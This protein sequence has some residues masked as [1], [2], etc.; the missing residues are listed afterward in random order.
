MLAKERQKTIIDI[1]SEKGSIGIHEL[2]ERLDVSEATVRND[3]KYLEQNGMLKRLHGGAVDL[4][5]MNEI[6]YEQRAVVHASEKER[7]GKKAAGL[8]AP[9]ETIFLDA[10]STV[11]ELATHLPSGFEF[12]VVTAALNVASAAGRHGNAHVH[13]VGGM[14]RSSLQ[15]LVGPKAIAGIKEIHAHKVFLSCSG[16][17]AGKGLTERHIFSAEVKKA[18]I[19][20]A[21][22]VILLADSTKMGRVFFAELAPLHKVDLLITD[23]AISDTNRTLLT[24]QGIEVLTV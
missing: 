11:M 16:F 3:L 20:A 5:R 9:G 1:V 21:D 7:I 12:N 4:S 14:L 8:I 24:A 10:G 15:E 18:M 6:T 13:L 19:A 17:D 22:Q 2:R 23:N